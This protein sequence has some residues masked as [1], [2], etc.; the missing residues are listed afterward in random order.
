MI[1]EHLLQHTSLIKRRDKQ[2][3]VEATE[4]AAKGPRNNLH[5]RK[6]EIELSIAI[7]RKRKK[8]KERE[9]QKTNIGIES[10]SKTQ[11]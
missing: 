11:V 3:A 10:T 9:R 6:K 7:E 2:K 5:K 1:L 8:K 4:A